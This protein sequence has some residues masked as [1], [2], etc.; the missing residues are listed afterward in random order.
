M[1][2]NFVAGD[3][4]LTAAGTLYSDWDDRQVPERLDCGRSRLE[5]AKAAEERQDKT[6]STSNIES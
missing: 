1:A 3:W 6:A 4:L 5:K 2:V